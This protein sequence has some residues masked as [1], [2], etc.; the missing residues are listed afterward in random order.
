MLLKSRVGFAIAGVVVIGGVSAVL[1]IR[2]LLPHN[3]AL[4]NPSQSQANVSPS[5]TPTT[6]PTSTPRP[7]PPAPT[8]TP[9]PTLEGTVG[10]I[11]SSSFVLQLDGGATPTVIVNGSTVYRY[12]GSPS[13]FNAL[14]TGMHVVVRG[15]YQSDGFLAT[16]VDSCSGTGC[17]T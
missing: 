1:A 12:N 3:A 7:R 17:D 14:T 2:P 8:R 5:A 6:V 9:I 4:A 11:G 13:T 15:A 16:R 10:N